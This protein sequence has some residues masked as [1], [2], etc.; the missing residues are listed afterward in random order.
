M[1]FNINITII[2]LSITLSLTMT[3]IILI[4]KTLI[5]NVSDN[6]N[7]LVCRLLYIQNY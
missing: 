5:N 4:D 2:N 1:V 3:L 7:I 6:Y